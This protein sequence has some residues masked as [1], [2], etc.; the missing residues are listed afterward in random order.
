MK[1]DANE[2]LISM[3]EEMTNDM[4]YPWKLLELDAMGRKKIV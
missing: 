2:T 1:I 4:L 3:E